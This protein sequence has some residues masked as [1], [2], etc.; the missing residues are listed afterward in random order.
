MARK[1]LG[2]NAKSYRQQLKLKLS[3]LVSTS[4][5]CPPAS[6]GWQ[7][8]STTLGPTPA[9]ASLGGG[10]PYYPLVN[11]APIPHLEE[12]QVG[13]PRGHWGLI[14]GVYGPERRS[15]CGGR[16]YAR[17]WPVSMSPSSCFCRILC[18]SFCMTR[19]GL[20]IL[21]VGTRSYYMCWVTPYLG[22]RSWG[23]GLAH[24]HV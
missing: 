11:Y 17:E 7:P 4:T 10:L 8:P 3:R 5:D 24:M 22:F 13:R 6:T 19:Q 21:A 23:L 1:L 15:E 16:M 18:R 20:G 9:S 2:A 14:K 12:Q